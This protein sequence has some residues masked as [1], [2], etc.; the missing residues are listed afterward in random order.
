[1]AQFDMG[2]FGKNTEAIA[3]GQVGKIYLLELADVFENDENPFE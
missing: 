2:V 3:D 1:M